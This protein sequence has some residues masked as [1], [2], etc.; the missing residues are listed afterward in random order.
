MLNL[1][2][3]SILLPRSEI[4]RLLRKYSSVEHSK[5]GPRPVSIKAIAGMA[6][7]RRH[8]VWDCR[9]PDLI[10]E[11]LQAVLS[12]ILRDIEAGRIRFARKAINIGGQSGLRG[13]AF[14][15]E[16]RTPPARP[17]PPQP[18]MV[19]ASDYNEWSRCQSC[20]SPHFSAFGAWFGCDGCLGEGDRRMLDIRLSK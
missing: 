19:G 9:D 12:P 10:S 15:V 14:D 20:G 8:T 13:S 3:S 11:R 16:Y 6:G 4:A 2:S 7:V 1:K 17:P 5:Y 18:R